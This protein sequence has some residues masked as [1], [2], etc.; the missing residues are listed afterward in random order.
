MTYGVVWEQVYSMLR[1]VGLPESRAFTAYTGDVTA[2]YGGLA[3]SR[4]HRPLVQVSTTP[5]LGHYADWQPTAALVAF[6][7]GWYIEA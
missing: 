5:A 6:C 3:T 1:K 4:P 2:I 7:G